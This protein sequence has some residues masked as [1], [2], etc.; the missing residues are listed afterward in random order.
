MEKKGTEAENNLIKPKHSGT[1]KV[2]FTEGLSSAL[3]VIP[4]IIYRFDYDGRIIY[5]SDAVKRYG[6]QPGELIGKYLPDLVNNADKEKASEWIKAWQTGD[7]NNEPIELRLLTKNQKEI[8]FQFYCIA[9][10]GLKASKNNIDSNGFMGIQCVAIDISE[11]KRADMEKDHLSKLRGFL[12]TTR[13]ICHELSQPVT[14][15]SGYSEILLLNR[16]EDDPQYEKLFEIKKQADTID[17][18]VRR[19]RYLVK[20]TMSDN[21]Q[22]NEII[23]GDD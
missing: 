18:I 16:T 5:I 1:A 13:S 10:K 20:Y 19:L 2:P 11:L 9:V 14:V 17:K 8:Y 21:S 22:G 3:S 15:I 4:D 7:G 6:C 12:E 23:G